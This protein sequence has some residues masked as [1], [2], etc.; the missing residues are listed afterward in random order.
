M[1]TRLLASLV[2]ALTLTGTAMAGG[3][4]KGADEPTE[5]S[6]KGTADGEADGE[7]P[8]AEET[9]YKQIKL[10]KI[11]EFRPTYKSAQGLLETV[12]LWE[13]QIIDIHEATKTAAGVAKEDPLQKA[14]NSMKRTAKGKLVVALN[15]GSTPRVSAKKDAPANVLTFVDQVNA[16]I[17]TCASIVANAKGIPDQVEGLVTEITGMPARITPE[18]L[19]KNNLQVGD[20]NSQV[21][22]AKHNLEATKDIKP[23]VKGV[24]LSAENYFSLVRSLA[25]TD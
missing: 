14:F 6:K 2:L 5:T 23:R 20:L 13:T 4:K 7:Q 22:V 18:L 12:T 17:D 1:K 25:E 8:S 10:G 9:Q 11:Q 21:K 19:A 24:V 15:T 16:S 3:G